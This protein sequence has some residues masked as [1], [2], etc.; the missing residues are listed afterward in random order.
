MLRFL[1]VQVL[2]DGVLSF[3]F[4]LWLKVDAQVF[5]HVRLGPHKQDLRSLVI[6]E[7][8]RLDRRPL[9]PVKNCLQ[10]LRVMRRFAAEVHT[11]LRGLLRVFDAENVAALLTHAK[12]LLHLAWM[13]WQLEFIRQIS[14]VAVFDNIVDAF[15]DGAR[16]FSGLLPLRLR[17][18]RLAGK[19]L[20]NLIRAV[21]DFLYKAPVCL[22]AAARTYLRHLFLP[23][24]K[25]AKEL[26]IL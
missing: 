17:L 22:A 3:L 4:Q 25:Q 11:F 14:M 7:G 12:R 19:L 16:R 23:D 10:A 5:H 8:G 1:Q 24:D 20:R 6:E 21:A 18:V 13:L 15:T 9:A 26:R 2:E